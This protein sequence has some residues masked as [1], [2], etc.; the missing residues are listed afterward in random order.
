MK[1]LVAILAV[2]FS[3]NSNVRANTC[4]QFN[5]IEKSKLTITL[6]N[7]A[8]DRMGAYDEIGTGA[9]TSLKKL[10]EEDLFSDFFGDV[11]YKQGPLKKIGL[12]KINVAFNQTAIIFEKEAEHLD[13]YNQYLNLVIAE[14]DAQVPIASGSIEMPFFLL[15]GGNHDDLLFSISRKLK[16][17]S[18]K[19]ELISLENNMGDRIQIK[20]TPSKIS[21][22]KKEDLIAK[23]NKL[24]SELD[25]ILKKKEST[26]ESHES[27][28]LNRAFDNA[29]NKATYLQDI[30]LNKIEGACLK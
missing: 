13:L 12:Q 16:L 5:L 25:V 30:L 23:I 10:N 27:M 3:V 20:I 24:R 1:S 29:L 19:G 7:T 17:N 4:Q 26:G 8:H 28:I 21:T 11:T 9:Y 2:I 6:K 22:I 18:L 15:S 14:E